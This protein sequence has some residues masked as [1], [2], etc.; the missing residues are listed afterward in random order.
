[1]LSSFL[2]CHSDQVR[3]KSVICC[4]AS[5]SSLT[6]LI[7]TTVEVL[8]CFTTISNQCAKVLASHPSAWP[9]KCREGSTNR[10]TMEHYRYQGR[11]KVREEG[12]N[13]KSYQCSHIFFQIFTEQ[14]L[15]HAVV[16]S[17]HL[18]SFP[19]EQSASLFHTSGSGQATDYSTSV[20]GLVC[21][22]FGNKPQMTGS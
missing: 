20:W 18:H 1:M 21:L 5:S 19:Q 15:F 6:A 8:E 9:H 22:S 11:C 7:F 17:F 2:S 16:I 12:A 14:F 4:A 13:S 10:V 3:S